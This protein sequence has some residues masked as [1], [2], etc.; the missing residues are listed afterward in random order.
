M[1]LSNYLRLPGDNNRLEMWHLIND[2]FPVYRTLIGPGFLESLE[3]IDKFLPLN[4][5]EFPTGMEVLDW[6]IPQGFKVNEAWVDDPQGKRIIDYAEDP[7]AIWTYSQ[8]FDGIVEH[9][10][11]LKHLVSEPNLP[12]AIPLRQSYYRE[13]WG[14]S[15]SD[16]LLQSLSAGRYKVHIDCE[17]FDDVL[18]IGEHFL[19]GKVED[20][21]LISSYLCHPLGANDNLSGVVV[22]VELFRMLVNL[23]ERYYSYRLA[24][25][26]ETIGVMT[27][28]ASYPE[29]L[30]KTMGGYQPAMCGDDAP[31]GIDRTKAGNSL[32]DRAIHHAMWVLNME[33]ISRPFNIYAG[34]DVPHLNS[35]G[36]D[37]PI[38]LISRGGS[39]PDGFPEYHTSLDD[40]TLVKSEK[41][42]ET[43]KV[44]WTAI[45]VIERTK[46]YKATY[47]ASPFMFRHGIFPYKHGAGVGGRANEIGDAYYAIMPMIDGTRDMLEIAEW[48]KLPI[49]AFDECVDDFLKAG[50]MEEIVDPSG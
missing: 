14:L 40:L 16:A 8:P 1:D 31:V 39:R 36:I 2:L 19:A 24:L 45:L 11:L 33:I 48:A 27:Y 26:P 15:C 41:L 37:L 13:N 22:A 5:A 49:F 38:A 6:V 9:E 3:I 44:L 47:K 34:S 46:T 35:I 10:E 7:Y 18:R 20:E 42:L 17:H 32:F 43:L 4:I 28:L 30:A 29:R 21:I 25:W 23:P 12:E 50:L